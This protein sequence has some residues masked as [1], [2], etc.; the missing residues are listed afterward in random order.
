M[1]LFDRTNFYYI[2]FSVVIYILVG[3]S[4]YLVVERVIYQEVEDRLKVERRDFENFIGVHGVWDESCYFVENKIELTPLNDT[5]QQFAAFK[6]TLLYN[7][8]NNEYVPFREYSFAR[9]VNGV[10]HKVSIRK[11][12][13]ESK[14]LLKS[15]TGIM[16]VVL[17][18]GLLILF[19][20]QRR[21]ARRIWAP[22]YDTLTRA[23]SFDLNEGKGL[24]LT[25]EQIFEFNELNSVLNKVT[26]KIA[27]DYTS[28]KE[29]TENASH[30]IQTPLALINSRVEELIQQ[31]NFSDEQMRW[32]QDIYQS[33]LRL[34][35]LHQALLLLS[36][37]EHGQFF[38]SETMDLGRLIEQKLEEFEEIFNHKALRVS[39]TLT[40]PFTV[41]M[42]PVLADV[43]ITNLLNNAVKHNVQGGEINIVVSAAGVALS[44]TGASLTTNPE[45]LFERFK[46]QN[47]TSASLGLGLAIVKKICDSYHLTINYG[48]N[49]NL[50]TLQLGRS[51][52]L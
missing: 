30:E 31:R 50:H 29:F 32:I 5:L 9:T 27:R 40:E 18:L 10:P 21:I 16:M 36:K 11:S 20:F 12:L 44:N 49:Q 33:A 38:E 8:Y 47:Q 41:Q 13:I 28:L 51:Q 43:L 23:R 2:V 52:V 7:R 25:K 48:V 15:I 46:K 1:K 34:S 4:F 14:K 19:I 37:I 3:V 24:S 17:S 45:R 42:S 6:D 26:D 39:V 35:K 22:F